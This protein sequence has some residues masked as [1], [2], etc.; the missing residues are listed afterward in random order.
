MTLASSPEVYQRYA[1][2][3]GLAPAHRLDQRAL[4]GM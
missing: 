2:L 4:S 1:A 3:R